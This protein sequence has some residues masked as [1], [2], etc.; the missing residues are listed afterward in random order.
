ML[1]ANLLQKIGFELYVRAPATLVQEL[2]VNLFHLHSC[3]LHRTTTL[4][5]HHHLLLLLHLST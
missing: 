4:T 1:A 3:C 2:P 5:L